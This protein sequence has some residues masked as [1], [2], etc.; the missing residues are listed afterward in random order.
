MQK[1]VRYLKSAL[2]SAS[3]AEASVV[4]APGKHTDKV[5]DSSTVAVSAVA[6]STSDADMAAHSSW[7]DDSTVE[8]WDST[9]EDSVTTVSTVDAGMAL[10]G[11]W[12]DDS[13]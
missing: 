1:S 11:S 10:C 2:G 7:A 12:A 3:M 8:G 13:A 5:Y 6:L 4:A 9:R